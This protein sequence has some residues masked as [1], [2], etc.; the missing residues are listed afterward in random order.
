VI[1]VWRLCKKQY[2]ETA[3]DG[4]GARRVGGRWNSRGNPVTYTSENLSLSALELLVHLDVVE[5][6]PDFVAIPADIPDELVVESLEADDLPDDWRR[7]PGHP[8][9]KRLGD[10]W[11][12]SAA[13][14]VMSVPSVVVPTEYNYLLNPDHD[15]ARRIQIGEPRPFEF[16][17]RRKTT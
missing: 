11:L 1:R 17:E 6:P 14:P 5:A 13:S 3:F 10:T 12:H 4:E 15:E 8:E 16:D 9:L 7:T 2:A